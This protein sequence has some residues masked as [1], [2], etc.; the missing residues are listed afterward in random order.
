MA[1]TDVSVDAVAS[2]PR[3]AA[4]AVP[5][6]PMRAPSLLSPRAPR[7]RAAL[8]QLGWSLASLGL[9]AGLWEGLWALGLLNPL[10]LPPP[11]LFLADLPGTLA[12]FDRAN[13]IG[14]RGGGG[15][16]MPPS[17]PSAGPPCG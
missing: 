16:V 3:R 13:R 14:S 17:P 10:L 9:F 2:A 12:Y 11:H 4:E 1:A 15:G 7:L 5:A 8:A 6:A